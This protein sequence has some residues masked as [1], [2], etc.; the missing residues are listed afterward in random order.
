MASDPPLP[1]NTL[2]AQP[3][4]NNNGIVDG[5]DLYDC[6]GQKWCDDCNDN[7]ILDWCDIDTGTSQDKLFGRPDGIPDECQL[8]FHPVPGRM[9]PAEPTPHPP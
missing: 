9:Q 3:T 2:W 7:G 8:K 1:P 5:T 6:A 4:R